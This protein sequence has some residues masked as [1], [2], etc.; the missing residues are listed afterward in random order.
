[1]CKI[2]LTEIPPENMSVKRIVQYSVLRHEGVHE[3]DRSGQLLTVKILV[4]T[5][6]CLAS[7]HPTMVWLASQLAAARRVVKL[8]V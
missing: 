8:F 5:E 3:P 7:V 1:M 4:Q 2:W 6:A